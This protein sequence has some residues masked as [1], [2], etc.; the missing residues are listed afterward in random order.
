VFVSIFTISAT[1][2]CTFG[3]GESFSFGSFF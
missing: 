3:G 1:S 2:P